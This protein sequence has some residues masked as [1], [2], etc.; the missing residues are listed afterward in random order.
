MR[1]LRVRG[2]VQFDQPATMQGVTLPAL[3]LFCALVAVSGEAAPWWTQKFNNFAAD[4]T[5][6]KDAPGVWTF[7]FPADTFTNYTSAVITTLDTHP[8]MTSDFI[9]GSAFRFRT[10]SGGAPAD[11]LVTFLR[12]LL[13]DFL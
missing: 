3:K 6:S 5:L 1:A 7:V 11:D 4:P 9:G 10:L 8:D 12:V 13:I 2:P